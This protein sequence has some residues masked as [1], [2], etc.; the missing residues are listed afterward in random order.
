[1]NEPPV[2]FG[3]KENIP[4]LPAALTT[5]E[6]DGLLPPKRLVIFSRQ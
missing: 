5:D 6:D 2:A 4:A 3:S 1:M